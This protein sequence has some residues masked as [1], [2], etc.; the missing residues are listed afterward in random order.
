MNE[1]PT[2]TCSQ[3]NQQ[4]R[5]AH[6]RAGDANG[7]RATLSCGCDVG[8]DIAEPMLAAENDWGRREVAVH[9]T[10]AAACPCQPC[11]GAQVK[12]A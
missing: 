7:Y 12:V 10:H 4:T 1:P 5:P 2:F 8:A 9:T 11:A 3:C 6:L